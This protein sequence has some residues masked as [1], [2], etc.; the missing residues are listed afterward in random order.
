[1]AAEVATAWAA[2]QT[3]HPLLARHREALHAATQ[4]PD[5]IVAAHARGEVSTVEFLQVRQSHLALESDYL[6]LAAR[7]LT[8]LAT[9][10]ALAGGE[11]TYHPQS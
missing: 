8:A 10:E 9:A 3:L 6:D 4:V 5:S 2:L 11:P 1:L 7:Y